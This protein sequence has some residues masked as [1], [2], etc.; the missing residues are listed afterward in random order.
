MMDENGGG[1]SLG[2]YPF[3]IK[4]LSIFVESVSLITSLM[5]QETLKII[6]DIEAV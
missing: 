1:N 5:I 2:K 3:D 6:A 4:L